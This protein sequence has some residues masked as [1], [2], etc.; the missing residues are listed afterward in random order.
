[1]EVRY[2]PDTESANVTY[3]PWFKTPFSSTSASCMGP[4]MYERSGHLCLILTSDRVL[5]LRTAVEMA[6]ASDVRDRSNVD[7][8]A[9]EAMLARRLQ[10]NSKQV[11]L[12]RLDL[13][14]CR[15]F[16]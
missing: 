8:V 3:S 5:N 12:E 2:P 4:R 6:L 10:N 9:V 1:M 15:V 16:I 14:R 7:G 13:F 11:P